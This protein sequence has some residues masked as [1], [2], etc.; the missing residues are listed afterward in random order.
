MITQVCPPVLYLTRLSEV[1]AEATDHW[2][3]SN[4]L[5]KDPKLQLSAPW[6]YMLASELNVHEGT[7]P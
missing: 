5:T 2:D 6:H 1:K 4:W 7:S 3:D